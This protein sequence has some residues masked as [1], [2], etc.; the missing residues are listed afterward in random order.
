MFLPSHH[1][2]IFPSP[3]FPSSA[4]IAR[5]RDAIL[6]VWSVLVP[7]SPSYIMPFTSLSTFFLPSSV[8]SS[9]SVS[10]QKEAVHYSLLPSPSLHHFVLFTTS[11]FFSLDKVI[12]KHF[13]SLLKLHTVSLSLSFSPTFPARY[14]SHFY[15]NIPRLLQND[16]QTL[17]F[18]LL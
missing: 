1:C 4:S 15:L 11:I 5:I 17:T 6:G 13:G 12:N 18:L 16:L 14:P 9:T 3:T 10:Y 7:F 2:S 8:P